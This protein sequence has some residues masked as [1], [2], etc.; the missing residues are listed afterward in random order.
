[1]VCCRLVFLGTNPGAS[2]RFEEAQNS[3]FTLGQGGPC[4][5][6]ATVDRISAPKGRGGTRPK[7]GTE[8]GLPMQG[9]V[10]TIETCLGDGHGINPVPAQSTGRFAKVTGGFLMTATS[11]PFFILGTT[12]APST[13]H[14]GRRG[15]A[16]LRK[17]TERRRGV[18]A[19]SAPTGKSWHSDPDPALARNQPRGEPG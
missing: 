10:L 12:T 13:L 6:Q 3:G 7:P 17:A 5:A 9:V 2:V 8:S 14:L 19:A 11:A 1:M 18:L 16:H 4:M 15:V